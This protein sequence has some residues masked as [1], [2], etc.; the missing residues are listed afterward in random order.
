MIQAHQGGGGLEVAGTARQFRKAAR[1]DVYM[2]EFD[3]QITRDGVIVINH[4]DTIMDLPGRECDHDGLRIHTVTYARVRQVRCAGEPLATLD[5][6]LTIFRRTDIRLNVEIKAWDNHF[7]Q[8]AAS[9]RSYARKVVGALDGG[10]YGGRYIL[11]FFDWRVLLPTVRRLH[12]DLYVIALERSSKMQQPGTRMYQAVRDAAALGADAFEPAVEVTQEGLL[13]F[14]AAQGMDPQLWYVNTPQD[15]R[16]AL[17]NGVNPI[18]TD[19][20]AMAK[21]VIAGAGTRGLVPAPVRHTVRARTVLSA[22]L[23][24]GRTAT[25]QVYGWGRVPPSAQAK[26]AAVELEVRTSAHDG[27][28]LTAM[29]EGGDAASG[30]SVGVPSGTATTTLLVS[31]GDRGSVRFAATA[32]TQVRVR[33]VGYRIAAYTPKP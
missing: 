1:S 10:G 14:I 29:P 17:A 15:V 8:P 9:L 3:A 32:S 19:D 31:P 22:T 21:D 23:K 12:P 25:A 26:L 24:A 33:L 18:S 6:V 27:G 11:S 2:V 20:P 13:R 28:S 16:F 5:E 30:V 4:S 7:S